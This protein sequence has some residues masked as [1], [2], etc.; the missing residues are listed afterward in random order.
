MRKEPHPLYPLQ[1]DD[2]ECPLP[3]LNDGRI[4]R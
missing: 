3:R 4:P 1:L 2:D